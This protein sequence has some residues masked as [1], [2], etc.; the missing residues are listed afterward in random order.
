MSD[1]VPNIAAQSD[2]LAKPRLLDN[3]VVRAMVHGARSRCPHC[4]AGKMFR[5]FLKVADRCPACGEELHHHRADDFPAYCVIVMVGHLIVP[6]VLFVETHFAPPYLVHLALW[7]PSVLGLCI[8]LIQPTK[9]AI[10]GLQW[11]LG[12]HGFEPAKRQRDAAL[13]GGTLTL[14]EAPPAAAAG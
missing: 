1:T 13:R 14:R 3:E 11:A 12:M 8:G 10:V 7:L 5:K 6:M 4:G 2:L 9:G